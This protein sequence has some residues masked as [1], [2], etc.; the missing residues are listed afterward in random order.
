MKTSEEFI[1]H[2]LIVEKKWR[3]R[4]EQEKCFATREPVAGEET[5]YCLDMF[6]YPS[7]DGLHV[8]HPVGFIASDVVARM[9]RM[10]G[11]NVLHPMGWDAFGLPA[12]RHAMKTGRHPAETVR[13]NAANY[14]RQMDMIGLSF[15]WDRSFSTTDTSYYRWTQ[16]MFVQ[17]YHAWFDKEKQKA[18]PISELPIPPELENA[19]KTAI[20]AYRDNYR[21]A[22][23]DETMVN[24]CPTLGCVVANEEVMADGRTEQ[25]FEVIRQKQRQLMMRI[26]AF[27][28]RLLD[29]L[30]DLDWPEA[31]KEQQRTWIGRSEGFKI[32]FPFSESDFITIFTTCPE[33]ISGVTFLALAPEHPLIK[34]ITSPEHETEVT[35]Y[36]ANALQKGDLL[37]KQQSDKTGVFT[38]SY[39]TNP[40]TNEKHPIFIADYVLMESGTGAVMGVPAHDERDFLFAQ[41]YKLPIKPVFIPQDAKKACAIKAG[42]TFWVGPGIALPNEAPIFEK[43]GLEGLDRKTFS[44]AIT[45]YLVKDGKAKASIQYRIRDWIFS[46]QRYWGEP[47]PLIHWE[48]GETTTVPEE[49]LPVILPELSDYIASESGDPPLARAAS[50][51]NVVDPKTGRKGQREVLTMPQWAG[52]CWYPLRFIDPHNSQEPVVAWKEKAWGPVDLYIGGAEHATLHLL[53]ARF[54]YMAL[55]DLGIVQTKEPFAKLVNQGLLGA[56]SYRNTRGVLIPV[57]EVETRENGNFYVKASSE[58]YDL[59]QSDVPLERVN[60]KMSKSLRNVV[61]PDEVICEY[62]ADAFRICLMFMGPVESSR[63]WEDEKVAASRRFLFR[64]WRF[65][66]QGKDRGM[67]ETIPAS[68]EDREI[69]RIVDHTIHAVETSIDTLRLNTGIAAFMKCLKNI[70]DCQVSHQTLE[71]LVLILSPFAPFT[72]EELW[73]RLGYKTSLSRHSWPDINPQSFEAPE[74]VQVVITVKGKKRGVIDVDVD[75]DNADLQAQALKVLEDTKNFS[76]KEVK[77]IVVRD[78][79][80]GS[81]KLIN[82]I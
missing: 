61:T 1:H 70:G 67:R 56:P 47:I 40:L 77:S 24:F 64:F 41:A 21:L 25:G 14:K 72:C 30:D 15:D 78:D 49:D 2:L 80:T 16:M 44:K 81:P 26:S 38:G 31:I 23:F 18:R 53:Y 7:G 35:A 43:L 52:S 75:I 58:H 32:N 45:N 39:A 28:E 82:F 71:K 76:A 34:E 8:G 79:K 10:K 36:V 68:E 55:S 48:D 33:T 69:I 63:E 50:W 46:R 20:E 4:W 9:K 29:G 12:E 74:R 22:Y 66:T 51:L 5:F 27:A 62:G 6:P 59:S 57:D 65:V 19:D 54:W 42:E 60:A 73:E 37:R 3:Y 17:L 11:V 13:E